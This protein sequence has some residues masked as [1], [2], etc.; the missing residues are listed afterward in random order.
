MHAM[1]LH[2]YTRMHTLTPRK[3]EAL[4]V[5]MYTYMHTLTPRKPEAL[6][7]GD[8]SSLS[9]HIRAHMRANAIA[10]ARKLSVY[11]C[12]KPLPPGA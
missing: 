5:H 1:H 3:P 7:E 11:L 10:R 6:F 4:Y 9:P 2:M 8:S 12:I